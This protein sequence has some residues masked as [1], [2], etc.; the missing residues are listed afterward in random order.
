MGV[1]LQDGNNVHGSSEQISFIDKKD[2][3]CV[4][5]MRPII[6][7][8]MIYYSFTHI[9]RTNDSVNSK[10]KAG[11]ATIYVADFKIWHQRLGHPSQQ[12]LRRM[13]ESTQK[14]PKDI[15][16]PKDIPICPGCAKG[17]MTSRS[18]PESSS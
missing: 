8:D 11:I 10:N 7:G 5:Q 4:I 16:I 3:K 15:I 18:F 14:F 17:K 1:F 2:G 13:P 9:M 12:A 6:K